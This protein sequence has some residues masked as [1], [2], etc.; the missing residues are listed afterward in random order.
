MEYDAFVQAVRRGAHLSRDQAERAAC[1]TLRT[2][3]GQLSDAETEMLGGRLP[4]ELRACL[5]PPGARMLELDE[6]MRRV[7]ERSGTDRERAARLAEVVLEVLALRISTGQVHDLEARLPRELCRALR[8]GIDERGPV[9]RRLSAGEF[10]AEVARRADVSQ[11]D[12]AQLVRG[13]METL[14]EA[15]G[16]VEFQDTIEQLPKGYASLL[17]AHA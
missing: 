14:R 4:N 16:E 11:R 12:A 2:L 6:L 7:A 1:A 3:A 9:L 13:V 8:R 5:T 17:P 15:V 10:V